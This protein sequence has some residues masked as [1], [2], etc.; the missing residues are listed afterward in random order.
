[1]IL[2][3]TKMNKYNKNINILFIIHFKYI[4]SLLTIFDSLQKSKV[5]KVTYTIHI[6]TY[7]IYEYTSLK[8]H[9]TTQDC[10]KYVFNKKKKKNQYNLL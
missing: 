5:F 2:F 1:L 9:P 3:G 10:T 8:T 4:T 6:L 7:N